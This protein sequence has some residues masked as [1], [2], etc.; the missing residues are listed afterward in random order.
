MVKYTD[1][2]VKKYKLATKGVDADGKKLCCECCV[3]RGLSYSFQSYVTKLVT[4]MYEIKDKYTFLKGDFDMLVKIMTG[5]FNSRICRCY[6]YKTP[7]NVYDERFKPIITHMFNKFTPT[8]TQVKILFEET[9]TDFG[10]DWIEICI[11]KDPEFVK[12]WRGELLN[13]YYDISD[14]VDDPIEYLVDRF[15]QDSLSLDFTTQKLLENDKEVVDKILLKKINDGEIYATLINNLYREGYEI[16]DDLIMAVVDTR[17]I[18]RFI[19]LII[20]HLSHCSDEFLLEVAKKVANLSPDN[21]SYKLLD[22]IKNKMIVNDIG[23]KELRYD[24]YLY[25]MIMKRKEFDDEGEDKDLNMTDPET[26][27]LNDIVI[28]YFKEIAPYF[29]DNYHYGLLLSI[30]DIMNIHYGVKNNM[31]DL[32]EKLFIDITQNP[33]YDF[34]CKSHPY[35]LFRYFIDNDV[36]I[37]SSMVDS[38]LEQFSS[39]CTEDLVLCISK[40]LSYKV[41][42][43]SLMLIIATKYYDNKPEILDMI[44]ATGQIFTYDDVW[45]IYDDNNYVYTDLF[46]I[47]IFGLSYTDEFVKEYIRRGHDIDQLVEIVIDNT[48]INF[49]WNIHHICS[50][51]EHNMVERLDRYITESPYDYDMTCF[52]IWA[53]HGAE[54]VLDKLLEKMKPDIDTVALLSIESTSIKIKEKL[55]AAYKS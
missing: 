30:C 40:L 43:T 4:L 12:K 51:R 16:S 8:D 55:V 18:D 24:I 46:N 11:K 5:K 1:V 20:S 33:R 13:I 52:H 14:Y 28:S 54:C 27:G 31:I 48:L 15:N 37:T 26:E 38:V 19:E 36:M 29:D 21:L 35:V 32:N 49:Y 3:D 47:G 53:R 45:T 7:K 23:N 39:L 25:F 6:R 22:T 44:K 10:C 42:V 17:Y 34:G 50:G 41:D 2:D 9:E